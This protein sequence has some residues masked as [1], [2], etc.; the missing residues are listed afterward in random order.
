MPR[1]WFLHV[2]AMIWVK[3]RCQRAS[4]GLRSC[5]S[6]EKLAYAD[7]DFKEVNQVVTGQIEEQLRANRRALEMAF[8]SPTT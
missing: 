8:S 3:N 2:F 7:A 1:T 6:Q 5:L 4:R